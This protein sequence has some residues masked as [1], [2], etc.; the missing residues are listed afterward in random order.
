MLEQKMNKA[1]GFSH[2]VQAS[3][4]SAIKLLLNTLWASNLTNK[5]MN[6]HKGAIIS[7]IFFEKTPIFGGKIISLPFRR[8]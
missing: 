4:S 6:N 3:V 1:L 7:G 8:S 2:L 5:S